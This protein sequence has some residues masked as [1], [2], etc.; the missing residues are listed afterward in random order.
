MGIMLK[1][2]EK[3][4]RCLKVGASDVYRKFSP[5]FDSLFNAQEV[6]RNDEE[7]ERMYVK[8][9]DFEQQLE[10]F[11]NSHADL[12]RFSVGYTG[13][14]KSTS[15]R[16][17]FG[18]GISREPYLNQEKK[19]IV[20]QTSLDGYQVKDMEKFDLAA[21]ISAVCSKLEKVHPELKALMKTPSGKQ[22]FYEFIQRHTGFAL[23]KINPVD[24][25]DMDEEELVREKLRSAYKE[26]PYEFQA[27]KLKF[28]IKKQYE[29]YERLIIILDDIES[30][31]SNFQTEIISYYLKLH[32]CMKNTD[33]PTNGHYHVNLLI[34]I[35]PHTYRICKKSREIETFTFNEP[36]ILKKES[37]DLEKL[38]EKR[39]KYYTE[40]LSEPIGNIE[41]WN[42]CYNV[43]S[44]LNRVFEGKYK[45]MI[46]NLCFMNVRES[47]ASYARIFANR[48]WV[49]KNKQRTDSF[50]V[51]FPDYALNNIT[52]V[53]ALAC[54]EEAVY[55][56]DS[57]VLP[58]IFY[59]TLEEDG[60]YSIYCLLVMRYFQRRLRD[61][62]GLNT[63]ALIN[64]KNEWN[65]I[66]GEIFTAKF[67]VALE[68]L[69]EKKI[70]RKSI[71]DVDDVTT[72]DDRESLKDDSL[73][74]ISCKG[75]ELMKM[76]R[77]DSVLLEMLREDVWRDYTNREY[78]ELPSSE[79]MKAG[80]QE[81]IY[82][83]LLEYVDYLCEREEDILSS[84]RIA[85]K[86][87]QYRSAF[88]NT[89]VTSFLLEGVK[90]SLNYSGFMEN[91]EE[92][93]RHVK[94]KVN[95]IM[96]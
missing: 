42:E 51:M 37:V 72:L 33:Y 89:A 66:F 54:N 49:Q 81:M 27:N 23:E 32:D 87:E 35:R 3:Y 13:I 64:I 60:D 46:C 73:L 39:F 30:L 85:G 82:Q 25:M 11:R 10:E 12:V 2:N 71:N 92:T 7:F 56:G 18:L 9:A 88:G 29:N 45:E 74:Y 57:S 16:H 96:R 48:F 83:D 69:F 63:E 55:W 93:Y 5:Q 59:T 47:L 21:R 36:T 4:L 75:I 70:L 95:N 40:H 53:R 77:R 14:G 90:N 52:V 65:N 58:N 68:E 19:E 20:F 44:K 15:I 1:I 91:L 61:V 17:C 31:P 50:S 78:T 34:S 41:T 62:Y 8:D 24:A 94:N 67:I 76:L 84:V 79:L 80:E 86:M 38:F 26:S 22:E 43:L 6:A 28:Y